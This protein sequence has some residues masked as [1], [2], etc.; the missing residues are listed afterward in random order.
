MLNDFVDKECLEVEVDK[1]SKND[2]TKSIDDTF[3]VIC[4]NL[5]F[6]EEGQR[7][8]S[9]FIDEWGIIINNSVYCGPN[10]TEPFTENHNKV[11]IIFHLQLLDWC[12]IR[13]GEDL[14][15]VF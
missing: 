13:S 12:H 4:L 5:S 7:Y 3:G 1:D 11:E 10:F 6:I 8:F 2:W 9:F 15:E 14:E